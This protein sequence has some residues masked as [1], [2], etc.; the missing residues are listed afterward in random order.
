MQKKKLLTIRYGK[1]AATYES[2]QTKKVF[3][4]IGS[5][6]PSLP[7]VELKYVDLFLKNL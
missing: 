7:G 5:L 4:N 1:C 2:A 6:N 3:F